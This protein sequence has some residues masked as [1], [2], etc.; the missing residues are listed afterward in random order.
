MAGHAANDDAGRRKR[1]GD[2]VLGLMSAAE[3]E[4]AERD[5]EV[6]A[7]FRDAV[8]QLA[9][10]M[11]AFDRTETPAAPSPERWQAIAAHI[12]ELP[13]MRHAALDGTGARKP[14]IG[15]VRRTFGMGLHALP[16]RRASFVALGLV[17]AFALGYLAGKL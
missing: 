3:R 15:A 10:S 11:H 8:I 17:V 7:A 1:A 12:A 5:L 2:Y 14:V 4:R 9:E 16:D 6:D 13:Q